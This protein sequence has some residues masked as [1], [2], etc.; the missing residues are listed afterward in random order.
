[1]LESILDRL[2]IAVEKVVQEREAQKTISQRLSNLAE[3]LE[4]K[5]ENAD[6]Q[7]QENQEPNP[8]L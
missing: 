3:L 6:D 5:P 2:E 7:T 8:Y 1:M 4:E